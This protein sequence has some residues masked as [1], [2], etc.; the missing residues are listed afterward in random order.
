VVFV[1]RYC[2]GGVC[3]AVAIVVFASSEK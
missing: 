3:R 2:D 1:F